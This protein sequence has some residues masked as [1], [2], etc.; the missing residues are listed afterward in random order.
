MRIRKHGYAVIPAVCIAFAATRAWAATVSKPAFSQVHGFYSSTISVKIS[1][2]TSGATIRYTTDGSKPTPSYGTVLA[3]GGS[4]S[5]SRTTCLRACAYQSGMTQSQVQTQ[6]YI[7]VNDVVSQA[8]PGGYPTKWGTGETWLRYSGWAD[9]E[10]DTSINATAVKNALKA[11]PS[12]CLAMAKADM[13]NSGQIYGGGGGAGNQN[14]LEKEASF[15]YMKAGGGGG[16]QQD[17]TMKSHSWKNCK[18]TLR[19]LFKSRDGGPATLNYPVFSDAPNSASTAKSTFGKLILRAGMNYSWGG[20]DGDDADET[21]YARDQWYRD[22]QIAMSGYGVHGT[23]VNLWIN[24]LYWGVYNIVERPDAR[25][26]AT[27]FGGAKGDY[28]AINH[29]KQFVDGELISGSLSRWSSLHSYVSANSLATDAAYNYVADRVDLTR[30]A[31]YMILNAY[32]DTDDWPR[33]NYYACFPKSGKLFYVG[34]DA[35]ISML[36]AS[37]W[38]AAHTA[39]KNGEY[40][41]GKLAQK[42]LQNKKFKQLLTSRVK[43]HCQGTGVLTDGPARTRWNKIC[44]RVSLGIDA[45]S[46]RWGDHLQRAMGAPKYTRTHWTAAR[47]HVYNRMGGAATRLVNAFKSA[48]WWD[49]SSEPTVPA[50]PSGLSATA[51]SSISIRLTWTDNS[52]DESGFKIERSLDGS[53][54]TQVATVGANVTSYANSGLNQGTRYYYRVRAYNGAGDSGYSNTADAATPT[55]LPP[56]AAPSG[57]AA[58]AQSS[59]AIRVTWTDNSNNETGFKL[60]RRLSGTTTWERVATPGANATSYTDSGLAAGTTYYYQVKASNAVG[61]SAY[62]NIADAT[63]PEELPPP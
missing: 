1:S 18:R 11:L 25:W 63:T 12:V 32:V 23:Y 17:C 46:A 31:D 62:S 35:E 21:V 34:W 48:G 56:P 40:R 61:D 24:G 7:F 2:A 38:P 51:Q 29:G 57:C 45:E 10:M 5:I 26:A 20:N 14:T 41:I 9:Y 36:D 30:F 49:E 33:G 37:G 58:A 39:Y 60:D 59:T 55:D 50:A 44:D 28:D 6:T 27:H 13:F 42:L 4:V 8:R 15:E 43:L 47:G 22:S 19:V 16:V 52:G 53:A 54:W 3:N